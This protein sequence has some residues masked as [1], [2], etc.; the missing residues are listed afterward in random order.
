MYQDDK[1]ILPYAT[2]VYHKSQTL[3][4]I[5][6]FGNFYTNK[7]SFLF[8]NMA[9]QYNN[10]FWIC[11]NVQDVVVD[12][13]SLL[14]LTLDGIVKIMYKDGIWET[15]DEN[16]REII[17]DMVEGTVSEKYYLTKTNKL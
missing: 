16:V 8:D 11:E 12:E 13:H 3:Y 17:G 6:V 9:V 2:Q 4:V 1:F 7:I 15:I 14:I 5:D 10:L